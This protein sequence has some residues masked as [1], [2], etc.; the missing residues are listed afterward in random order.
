MTA[1]TT[2]Y[3]EP[4]TTRE[5]WGAWFLKTLES[6]SNASRHGRAAQRA[7]KL[8]ALSDEQ[9]AKRGLTREGIAPHV[10]GNYYYI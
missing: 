8:Y 1:Q 3:A 4:S 6:I 5:S 9:L 2:N 10:F 7:S